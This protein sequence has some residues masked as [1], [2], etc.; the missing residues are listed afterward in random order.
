MCGL[1]NC[2]AKQIG[3]MLGVMYGVTLGDT[4][5]HACSHV[6]HLIKSVALT[7]LI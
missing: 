3:A 6:A 4:L 5:W 7:I 2:E 1:H